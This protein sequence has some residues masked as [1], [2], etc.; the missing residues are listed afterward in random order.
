MGRIYQR[1]VRQTEQFV[2]DRIVTFVRVAALK[3]SPAAA[4]DQQH[5]AGEYGLLFP[6]INKGLT[7][8]WL[9][10]IRFCDIVD[11]QPAKDPSG[12]GQ[13]R[14][15]ETQYCKPKFI[16]GCRGH[17]FRTGPCSPRACQSERG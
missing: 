12:S 7:W 11:I 8:S 2:D 16:G 13:E 5:I 15:Y 3:V 9:Q 4:A 6:R 10:V 1:L 17:L 14:R